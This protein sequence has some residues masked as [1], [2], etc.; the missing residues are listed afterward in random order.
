MRP[1]G[2]VLG[3]RDV[4]LPRVPIVDIRYFLEQRLNFIEQFYVRSS[5]PFVE[6]KRKIEAEEEPFV[7]PQ[8]IRG[9][10]RMALT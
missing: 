10:N 9:Q 3:G 7:S 5:A 6:I 1:H 8:G 2:I 4:G